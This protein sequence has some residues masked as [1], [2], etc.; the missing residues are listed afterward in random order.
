MPAK[1]PGVYRDGGFV[2]PDGSRVQPVSIPWSIPL[3]RAVKPYGESL[4]GPAGNGNYFDSPFEAAEA[5]AEL[6][7]G[8]PSMR[9]LGG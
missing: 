6:G 3:W 1:L 8:T 9:P 4:K 5:L 2:Y 7:F